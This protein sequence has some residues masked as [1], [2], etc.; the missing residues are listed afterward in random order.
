MYFNCLSNVNALEY[1]E[2]LNSELE[3][4]IGKSSY[5]N[6]STLHFKAYRNAF[7]DHHGCSRYTNTRRVMCESA[8]AAVSPAPDPT[9]SGQG[10]PVSNRSVCT[11]AVSELVLGAT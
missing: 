9:H 8:A 1:V 11:Q 7:I 10:E 3:N 6:L 5:T 4:D 2:N